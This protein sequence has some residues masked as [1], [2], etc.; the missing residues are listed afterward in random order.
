MK[1]KFDTRMTEFDAAKA[2]IDLRKE[3]N[4]IAFEIHKDE[5][6]HMLEEF[7]A[8]NEW[9]TDWAMYWMLSLNLDMDTLTRR[10][11]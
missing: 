8:K 2:E 7:K 1:A 10:S 9:A 6:K 4:S 3:E 5:K 11:S